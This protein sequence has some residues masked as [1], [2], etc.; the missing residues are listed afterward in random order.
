MGY[1][2]FLQKHLVFCGV[3]HLLISMHMPLL[4]QMTRGLILVLIA[5]DLNLSSYKTKAVF[6]SLQLFA[7]E[8]LGRESRKQKGNYSTGHHFKG[9]IFMPCARLG[10]KADVGSCLSTS[11]SVDSSLRTQPHFSYAGATVC[12]FSSSYCSQMKNNPTSALKE[13]DLLVW[14][15]T[16]CSDLSVISNTLKEQRTVDKDRKK[17]LRISLIV[18]WWIHSVLEI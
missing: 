4:L 9:S 5:W 10:C 3:S 13:K 15:R 14:F 12:W 7:A 1:F 11:R 8:I 2:S 6:S 18:K 17:W 16:K